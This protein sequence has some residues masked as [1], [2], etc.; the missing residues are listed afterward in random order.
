VLIQETDNWF[1]QC[2]AFCIYFRWFW[3]SWQYARYFL[4]HYSRSQLSITIR[5]M[6]GLRLGFYD[7]VSILKF[8]PG[9]GVWGYGLDYITGVSI[10]EILLAEKL[11]N[12]L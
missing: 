9:F 2:L 3:L 8:E 6:L 10:L 4:Q 12:F 5:E 7:K 1:F 11:Y